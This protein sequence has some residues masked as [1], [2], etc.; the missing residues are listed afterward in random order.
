MILG[1][2]SASIFIAEIISLKST[3]T[4]KIG[5]SDMNEDHIIAAIL[6]AGMVSR[7]KDDEIKPKDVIA[8]YGLTLTELIATQRT[9]R[10]LPESQ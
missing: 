7:G 3:I 10:D 5:G 9:R 4:P 1:E 2:K 8:L 6:T